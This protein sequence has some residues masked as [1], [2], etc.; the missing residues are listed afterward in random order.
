MAFSI[1]PNT[2]N[3]VRSVSKALDH[4]Q[5]VSGRTPVRITVASSSPLASM[6][7]IYGMDVEV[8]EDCPADQFF[9]F[10]D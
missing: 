8:H 1:D 9:L 2:E 5:R 10:T 6:T 7:Q 3:L 4:C